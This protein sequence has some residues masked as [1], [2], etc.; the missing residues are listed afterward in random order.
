MVVALDTP[1]FGKVNFDYNEDGTINAV[2]QN[3]A[4]SKFNC[5]D[6]ANWLVC[7]EQCDR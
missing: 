7:T 6:D 1:F 5:V 4:E 3:A 2:S